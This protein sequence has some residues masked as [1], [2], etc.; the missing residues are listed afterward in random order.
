MFSPYDVYVI[1]VNDIGPAVTTPQ[2]VTAYTGEDGLQSTSDFLIRRR[3]VGKY[4]RH[5]VTASSKAV[6]TVRVT[7]SRHGYPEFR[8]RETY[9]ILN[10]KSCMLA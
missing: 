5:W 10:A 6:G 1:S 2:L 8:P 9:E 7:P 3:K 4:G